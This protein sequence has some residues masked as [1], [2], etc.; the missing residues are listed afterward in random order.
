VCFS[1][2]YLSFK[3]QMEQQKSHMYRFSRTYDL[4]NRVKST[5]WMFADDCLMYRE[6][7]DGHQNTTSGS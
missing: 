7:H 3:A 1:S 5:V 2:L 4:A 6:I